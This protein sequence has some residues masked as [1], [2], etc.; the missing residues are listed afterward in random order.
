MITVTYMSGGVH[1]YGMGYDIRLRN[2]LAVW[3]ILLHSGCQV[4]VR[5]SNEPI[6]AVAD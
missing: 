6:V 5:Y 1:L 2:P 4:Q 3:Y